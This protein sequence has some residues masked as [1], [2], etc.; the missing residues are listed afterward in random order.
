MEV[1]LSTQLEEK[2][3]QLVSASGRSREA[4]LEDAIACYVQEL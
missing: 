3:D 4:F 1:L 2:I